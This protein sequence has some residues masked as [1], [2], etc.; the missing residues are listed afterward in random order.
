MD[1][2]GRRA[3]SLARLGAYTLL[4]VFLISLLSAVLPPPLD[5]PDRA[6][7]LIAEL[8]ERSSLPLVALLLLYAG[9]AD[10]AQP[11]LWEVGLLA[12]WLRPLL[13][14]VALAYLLLAIAVIGLAQRIEVTGVGQ[15]TSQVQTSLQTL[16]RLRQGVDSAADP[17]QLR[18]LLSHD[19]ALMEAMRQA[20]VPA[21]EAGTLSEQ[22]ALA[23]QLLERAEL[24]LRDASQR[25]R[26]DAS[27]N[28][29]R[30]ALRLVLLAL[31][32]GSFFLL[33][34]FIWPRSVAATL[35]RAIERRD[36]RAREDDEKI[37]EGMEEDKE[38]GE[39]ERHQPSPP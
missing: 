18:Q 13:R 34:G 7:A 15:L 21:G 6:M 39:L 36:A 3:R 24:N 32:Y 37:E 23:R 26:A 5:N 25:R 11:A 12:R 2:T 9:L 30:Q 19:P 27:G 16:E 20:G 35:E 28:L 1:F 10:D 4:A 31:A 14:L 22:R 17:Q 33:A 8:L 29:T 38:G